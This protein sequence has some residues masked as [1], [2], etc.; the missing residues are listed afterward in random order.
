MSKLDIH[1]CPETGICSIIKPDGG[2]IDLMPGEVSGLKDAGGQDGIK[3]ALAEVDSG[4]ADKLA[5]EEL[6]QITKALG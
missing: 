6:E 1:L 3:Q 2:K 5:P 4:F